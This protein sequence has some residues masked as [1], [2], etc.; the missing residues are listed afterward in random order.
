[1]VVVR[2]RKVASM[3]FTDNVALVAGCQRDLEALVAAYL[4]WCNLLGLKV[5][6]IQV[7]TNLPGHRTTKVGDL[8]AKT[9][10]IF[11]MVGVDLGTDGR[12]AMVLRLA[13]HL[14]FA[15][16]SSTVHAGDEYVCY[17]VCCGGR[18]CHLRQ[19]TGVKSEAFALLSWLH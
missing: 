14:G 18:L 4:Q 19:C 1:M 5:T 12:L 11:K 13:P 3:S 8:A 6:K 9:S 7:W 15:D 10:P 16:S 17:V 2:G